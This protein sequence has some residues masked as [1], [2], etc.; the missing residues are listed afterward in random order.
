M[1]TKSCH[2]SQFQNKVAHRETKIQGLS[3][4][5]IGTLVN[6]GARIEI[7]A[8]RLQVSI[9]LSKQFHIVPIYLPWNGNTCVFV[10][11][12]ESKGQ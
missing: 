8:I 2:F 1:F 7:L 11:D 6:E 5:S 3:N 10:I 12:K 4:L 9:A